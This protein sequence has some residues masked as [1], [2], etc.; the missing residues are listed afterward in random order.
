MRHDPAA[1]HR[2]DPRR[3]RCAVGQCLRRGHPR[4]PPTTTMPRPSSRWSPP[5]T[6]TPI[7]SPRSSAMRSTS[8]PWCTS[9]ATDPHS[10]EATPQDRLAVEKAD[11]I[12]A[13][14]AGY[15]S[16]ITQLASSADK[17]DAVYQV[18][19]G[20]ADHDHEEHHRRRVLSERA[21][22]VRPAAHGAVHPRGRR[23]PGR[24]D[25]TA[26][27]S[28]CRRRRGPRAADQRPGRAQPTAAGIRAQL[29]EHRGR[30]RTP[31]GARRLRGSNRPSVPQ[32]SRPRQRHPPGSTATLCSG[33][34]TSTCS[35][36]TPRPRPSRPPASAMRRERQAPWSW[37]SPK[38][39]TRTA[40]A[41]WTG[42]T[43]TS[44]P[45][46]LPCRR[47]AD[48]RGSTGAAAARGVGALRR[49]HPV[50]AGE[51]LPGGRGVPGG[52]GAQRL[53]G[54]RRF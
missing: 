13:N 26:R 54:S 45:S 34:R 51:P 5:P 35:P 33:A 25:S 7:S 17:E 15:D 40:P 38:P 48:R 3:T 4:P 28:L 22:L 10:Y 44:T 19:E 50:G 41:T 37:S 21:H 29:P 27:G 42:W 16:F 39:S 43:P 18:T 1:Q 52:A 36:T 32:H 46:K 23:A 9:T 47:P 11:L 14:G 6:S 2:P 20:S 49:P 24:D 53:R 8:R 31:A 12:V 30:L